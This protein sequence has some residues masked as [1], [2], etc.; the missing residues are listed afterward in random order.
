M[1]HEVVKLTLENHPTNTK[2]LGYVLDEDKLLQLNNRIYVPNSSELRNI[3]LSEVHNTSYSV[4]LGVNKI[5]LDLKKLYFW[6]CIRVDIVL[7]VDK[8]LE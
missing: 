8:C 1:V 4:H 5:Y 2:V 7:Y 3:I 6:Q